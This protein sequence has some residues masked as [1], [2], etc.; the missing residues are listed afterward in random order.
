MSLFTVG[1]LA[2]GLLL[3]VGGAEIFV[4]GASTLAALAGISPLVIGLTVVAFGT[5][6]P[7]VAVSVQSA[8]SGAAD[9]ALGNVVGSNICNILLILGISA[10]VAPLVVAQQLVRLDVPVMIGVSLLVLLF[11]FDGAIGRLDGGLLFAGAIGYTTFLVVQS[12]KETRE[13]VKREHEVEFAMAG[14]SPRG[15]VSSLALLLAGLAL[16]VLGSRWLVSG[17]VTIAQAFGITELVIGLTVVALGTSLPEI[18]TSV[19]ATLRGQRD[20]AVG[21]VVG[22]NIFNVLM[23]LG[24][25]GVVAPAGIPV[26]AAALRFDIPVMIAV[27]IACL[28]IFFTDNRIDRWEGLLFLGYYTAYVSYL[29]LASSRHEALPVFSG[30]MGLFVIPLTLITLAIVLVRSFRLG[31][32]GR[33][34]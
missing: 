25:T 29:I 18:A 1:L 30:I 31:K 10:T 11:G 14:P 32:E 17:A 27:S 26:P 21:N 16:L 13:A 24:I 28:P 4:R 6:A 12:R 15:A 19:I 8:L 2:V 5:S 23:V 20:I 3:L 7:E 33:S 22:S 9:I 34:A